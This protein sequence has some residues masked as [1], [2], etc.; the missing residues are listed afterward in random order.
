MPAPLER[1]LRGRPIHL[2]GLGPNLEARADPAT[3]DV[4]A[5][6]A[7]RRAPAQLLLVATSRPGDLAVWD[8]PLQAL[9]QDLRV[10][11]LCHELA[12]ESLSEADVAAYLAAVSAGAPLPEGLAGLVF[13]AVAVVRL[14]AVAFLAVRRPPF[15][16]ST[17]AFRTAMRS[18]TLVASGGASATVTSLPFFFAVTS[19]F[20]RSV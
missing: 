19:F 1:V 11:Q 8:H 5:A 15:A 4:L 6:L 18:M 12:V 2:R 14:A 10:H 16:A 7:R 9:T 20:T 17:L 13:R 3:V